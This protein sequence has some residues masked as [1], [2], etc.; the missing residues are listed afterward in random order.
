MNL[1]VTGSAGHLGEGLMRTLRSA[2]RHAVGLD[3]KPS[4]YTD[5]V[6]SITDRDLVARSLRG[7]DAVIHA[8]TFA[9]GPTHPP[10]GSPKMWRPSG[11]TST[12]SP[13]RPPKT[14]A[15]CSPR[16]TVCPVWCC[17]PR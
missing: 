14:C 2:G 3:V 12:G 15:P 1:V 16:I 10:P 4:P 6:G 11:A 17:T 9:A 7:I 5:I 8:A 13:R